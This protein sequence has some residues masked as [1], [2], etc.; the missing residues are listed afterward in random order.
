MRKPSWL[1]PLIIG[2]LALVL[3]LGVS[4]CGSDDDGGDTGSTTSGA[5]STE[6]SAEGGG[7]SVVAD[8]EAVVAEAQQAATEW[9]GPEE[10]V[11]PPAGKK[12]IAVIYCG[13]TGVACKVSAEG[14]EEAGEV[15]GWEVTAIDGQQQPTVQNQAIRNAITQNVDGIVIDAVP[16]AIVAGALAE[17]KKAGIAVV[18][19]LSKP[20]GAP[21]VDYQIDFDRYGAGVLTGNWVVA[22]SQGDATLLNVT[23][24]VF[25]EVQQYY[26]GLESVIDKCEGCEIAATEEFSIAQA[27][28]RVSPLVTNALRTNPDINYVMSPFDS[29][30]PFIT[31][32]V[33]QAG[34]QDSVK[35]ASEG[36]SG[37]E[38]EAL[39][40]GSLTATVGIPLNWLGWQGMDAMVRVLAEAELP[41]EYP[42]PPLR[43]FV[44]PEAP[45]PPAWGG[46]VNYQERYAEL[47]GK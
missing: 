23:E 7:D 26:E 39:K 11:T 43:L 33:R 36:A 3:A 31:E 47:W 2:C 40:D 8:A 21:N 1:T 28:Q 19:I 18:A 46:D 34:K 20:T 14:V 32:G 16:P 41:S 22:D 5:S 25:V 42:S 13:A 24:P 35:V 4:A 45:E 27:S 9:P 38:I 44:S 29:V 12:K 6:A 15:L 37:S 17:A 10:A 30:V